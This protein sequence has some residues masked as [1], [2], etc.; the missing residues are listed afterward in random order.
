[1]RE[2]ENMPQAELLSS[3]LE[4]LTATKDLWVRVR[5]RV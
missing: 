5:V 4:N 3:P 1:M 2:E